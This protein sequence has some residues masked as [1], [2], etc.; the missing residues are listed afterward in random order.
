MGYISKESIVK[1]G[2]TN[3]CEKQLRNIQHP[4]MDNVQMVKDLGT[5]IINGI[6]SSNP[7]H[8]G[9]VSYAEEQQNR[10]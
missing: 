7:S 1:R 4:Q 3:G 10:F 6:H 9:S 2:K 5:L 8:Q